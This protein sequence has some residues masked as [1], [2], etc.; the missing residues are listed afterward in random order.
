MNQPGT[1]MTTIDDR[2]RLHRES[3]RS[4]DAT[5]YV[6]EHRLTR[7]TVS[8]TRL[9]GEARADGEVRQQ[10]LRDIHWLSLARHRSVVSVLD[11]GLEEDGAPWLVTELLDGRTLDATL[12]TRRRLPPDEAMSLALE[13]GSAL[14]HAHDKELLHAGLHPGAIFLPSRSR[15]ELEGKLGF[16]T[17]SA[18][19][20]TFGLGPNPAAQL[21]GPLAAMGYAAPERLAGEAPNPRTDIHALGAILYECLTGELPSRDGTPEAPKVLVDDVPG[22]L[23]EAVMKAIAPPQQRFDTAAAFVASLQEARRSE[24]PPP[25]KPTPHRR[26][27]ARAVYATPVRLI[28]GSESLDGRSEDVSEG[29]MLAL[30]HGRVERGERVQVRFALPTSG[31]RITVPAEIRWCRDARGGMNAIGIAFQEPDTTMVEDIAMY[32]AFFGAESTES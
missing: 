3:G 6:A 5:L 1:T 29:G 22:M 2:Y 9:R 32:V 28:H 16:S 30:V 17:S 13:I 31:D 27:A 20:L 26:A 12:A 23:S 24:P 11:A 18:K 25:S 19:L 21:E 7:R 4:E 15:R 8:L 10:Q 14:A